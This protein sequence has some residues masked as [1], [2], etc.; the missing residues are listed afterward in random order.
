MKQKQRTALF[1]IMGVWI[2]TATLLLIATN[3]FAQGRPGSGNVY[4]QLQIFS[5][6]LMKLRQNYVTELS[7][8]ELIEAAIK[9]MLGSTDPHTTYFTSDEFKD[10]TTSTKGSFGGLG[11]QIDKIGDYITVVSPIEGTPA[12]RMGITAGD[13]IIKVDGKS[14]VGFSTDESIKH[15]RGDVG[16]TVV[17]TISR[18][19]NA[20]PIDFTIVREVIKI[21]SVP[22]SFKMD[23]GVG[24]LR[25][26][27]FNENTVT[28][29]R[30][31]LQ[32]LEEEGINGLIV[33]LRF[34]PGGLLDQAVDTVNEFIGGNKLVVE[35]KGRTRQDALYTRYNTKPREYP[36]I[37]LVNE[38][39]A[40]ASEIFA[41]SLQDWDKGLVVG[42]NTF[43]KGSVQQLMPLS[44]GNGIKVTTSYY[45]IKSGR[46][47]HKMSNDKRLKG[48]EVSEDELSKEDEENHNKVYYTSQNREVYGGGGITPDI[49]VEN[50]FLTLFSADLRRKN[51][52][53]NFAVDYLIDHNH[54]ISKNPEITDRIMQDFL[55]YAKT[56]DITYT[57][58]DL[59]SSR[60]YIE[61]T[62]KSELV[63][64]VHGDLE[65]YKITVS[66]DK[67]LLEAVSLFNRFK[68]LDE[69]FIYADSHKKER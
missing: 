62:I 54:N 51:V 68:T 56:Q 32:S 12:F 42:K 50:D 10:F 27:Q 37:V 65:A 48:Q 40:S 55:T 28:E 19:G 57:M 49:V 60:A 4:N 11:I 67:Q 61:N 15:M 34:N 63:R 33:D 30:S 1:T 7:D 14:I 36:I 18:P 38:A 17:I 53:F 43:G 66:Q 5:E 13:R 25:I 16:S 22:Y 64:K 21:K 52:F 29:L 58:A 2:L 39:S 3:A 26:S 45:Y 6:V 69:M 47:I 24:Y 44:N 23:N 31:A 46:C 9:G 59:D 35:T 8:E 41:G 20:N